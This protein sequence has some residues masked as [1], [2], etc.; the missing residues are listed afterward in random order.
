MVFGVLKGAARK[1]C[2]G[3]KG[4][5]K[6]RK[7]GDF[8]KRTVAG[9]IADCFSPE[10]RAIRNGQSGILACRHVLALKAWPWLME[11]ADTLKC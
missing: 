8:L 3:G 10:H 5:G 7:Y 11:K 4:K 2:E 1:G 9:L 6:K